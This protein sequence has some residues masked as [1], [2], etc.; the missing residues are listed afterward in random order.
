[1]SRSCR[2][3]NL[4]WVPSGGTTQCQCRHNNVTALK[5]T[6]KS[7]L[8]CKSDCTAFKSCCFKGRV[9][10]AEV[11]IFERC[12]GTLGKVDVQ[13]PLHGLNEMH[14]FCSC[15]VCIPGPY[16]GLEAPFRTCQR[17]CTPSYQTLPL[18]LAPAV[19]IALT[20]TLRICKCHVTSALNLAPVVNGRRAFA[21]AKEIHP[22]HRPVTNDVTKTNVFSVCILAVYLCSL[23]VL[24]S[25]VS[26]W[27]KRIAQVRQEYERRVTSSREFYEASVRKVRQASSPAPALTSAMDRLKSEYTCTFATVCGFRWWFVCFLFVEWLVGCWRR[28]VFPSKRRCWLLIFVVVTIPFWLW[29]RQAESCRLFHV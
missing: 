22:K 17:Q 24:P 2:R 7:S 14:L 16:F 27:S 13:T 5:E 9:W 3:W 19:H 26:K 28:T 11:C 8:A 10:I 4:A 15:C 18:R 1:M 29:S 12:C 23:G 21:N 20:L 6:S 25:T